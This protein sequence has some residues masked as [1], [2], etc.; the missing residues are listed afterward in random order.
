MAST[1]VTVGIDVA[2]A[3]LD[4]A[5]RPDGE[6]WQVPN[7]EDGVAALVARRRPLAPALVVLEAT[8]GLEVLAA[9]ALA[10][11]GLPVAV[12]NPRQVRDFAKAVGQLAQP[13][14][15]DAALLARFGEAVRPAPRPLPDAAQQALA[16]LLARRRQVVAMRTAERQRRAPARPPV[17][18]RVEAHVAWL[19]RELGA[20]DAELGQALRA[21][22]VWREREDLLRSVPGVGPVVA[23]TLLAEL[24]ELGAL[25]RKRL[26][27]LVGP[28]PLACDSGALRGQ[29]LVWGG[30]G[31]VRAARYMAALVGVRHNPV[32]R[33]FY[34]RLLRAGKAK[35]VALTACMH[36][37]LTI[38]N[39]IVH[40]RTPWRQPPLAVGT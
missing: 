3:H 34:Q 32:L 1:P 35:K 11:A 10:A 28:A 4:V 40:A 31:R 25:D 22:P 6:R 9:A 8:G 30:R 26:A 37:L 19:A 12:V 27:A 18:R 36:K 21:S 2:K 23:T 29:R 15:L 33:A 17:R 16:A 7:D 13:D 38:L 20:L 5:A 24:P 14:A 39:A